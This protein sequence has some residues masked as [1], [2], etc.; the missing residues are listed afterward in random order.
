MKRACSEAGWSI[1]VGVLC[2]ACSSSSATGV[3]MDGGSTPDGISPHVGHDAHGEPPSSGSGSGG[4]PRHDG[5]GSG[6]HDAGG[7]GAHDGG[8]GAGD[9]SGTDA[10]S[11]SGEDA[12]SGG[13]TVGDSGGLLT[14]AMNPGPDAGSVG[15]IPGGQIGVGTTLSGCEI[16]PAD[17]PWNVR[18]DGPHVQ[19]VT[20]Y[21]SIPQG[22]TLHADFGDFTPDG[23]GIPYEVV[24]ASQAFV[25][26]KFGCFAD[27]SDPGPAGWSTAPMASTSDCMDEGSGTELGVTTYPFFTGMPIEGNPAAGSGGTPGALPGDQHALILQQGTSGCTLW[28]AWNCVQNPAPFN[29]AN[30]AKFD[31]TSNALRPAGWTS[32]DAAGLPIFAGLVRLADVKAG[33]I[34]HAIRVTFNDTQLGYISPATHASGNEPLGGTYP[35]MGLRLRLRSS[36]AI[37]S[38]PAPAQVVLK[39]MQEYGFLVADV[40]TDWYFQGDSDNG[41]NDTATDGQDTWF[42]EIIDGTNNVQGSDFEVVYTGDP[43][44]TGL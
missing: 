31:L 24:P 42:D 11:D 35:P 4:S 44:N 9:D 38:Y 40:G 1:V 6:S 10:E 16:F 20:S 18:V 23:Y 5:G 32:A 15:G 43:V 36:F 8:G 17:N 27:Q 33:A 12:D 28:E 37:A 7:G 26:T 22:T 3:S 34:T 19:V 21:T 13:G 41:W 2:A 25:Q 14:D 30:G 29:C 39:A